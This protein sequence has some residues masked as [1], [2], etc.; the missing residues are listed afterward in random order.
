ME[1]E[2]H[3]NLLNELNNPEITHDRRTEI[4]QELR[5]DYGTVHT[6][7]ESITTERNRLTEDN[8]SLVVA[9]SKLFRQL[10]IQDNPDL[11]KKDEEKSF[12]ESI[13][14]EDLEK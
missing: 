14:L 8:Q 4:L 5:Q 13:R 2:T 7:F 6:D 12:S 3:E 1:R 9:N 11:K 10:G